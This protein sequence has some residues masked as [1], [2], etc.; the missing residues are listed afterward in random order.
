MKKLLALAILFTVAITTMA[1]RNTYV[2]KNGTESFI[3]YVTTTDSTL[4]YIDS[5]VLA[6][7]E[8]GVV[9]ATVIGY[10]Y[11]TAYAVTGVVTARF[12]KRRGTL[13]LGTV[14]EE[15]TITA[16]AALGTATFTLVASGNKIY[17]RVKGKAATNIRW[18]AVLK[19]KSI[20]YA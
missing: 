17:L 11:D 20:K 4:T 15:Q 8:A 19:R 18:G 1:Q 7:N 3:T 6:T 12:N 14:V 13:T 16:D 2:Q 10:A 9:E 5:V